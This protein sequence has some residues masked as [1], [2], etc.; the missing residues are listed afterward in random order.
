MKIIILCYIVF[1]CNDIIETTAAHFLKR[2]QVVK[3]HRHEFKSEST[4]NELACNTLIHKK[5]FKAK[6]IHFFPSPLD[7]PWHFCAKKIFLILNTYL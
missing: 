1:Q 2:N 7:E 6:S 5:N 3:L 4:L